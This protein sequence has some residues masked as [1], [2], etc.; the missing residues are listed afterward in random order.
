MKQG[1]IWRWRDCVIM[2]HTGVS[3]SK[4]GMNRLYPPAVRVPRLDSVWS[5]VSIYC[6][7][8]SLL[9]LTKFLLLVRL[10]SPRLIVLGVFI[11]QWEGHSFGL[12]QDLAHHDNQSWTTRGSFCFSTHS[13]PHSSSAIWG[14]IRSEDSGDYSLIVE[15]Q[16]PPLLWGPDALFRLVGWTFFNGKPPE[17]HGTDK[18]LGDSEGEHYPVNLLYQW[19]VRI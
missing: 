6:I 14:E 12:A 7:K 11:L 19:S 15:Q 10:E 1:R 4:S 16:L 2:S 13:Q 17:A 9:E 3:H 5:I 8:N 18:L